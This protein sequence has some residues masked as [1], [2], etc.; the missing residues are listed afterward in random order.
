MTDTTFTHEL[1]SADDLREDS[2]PDLVA[3]EPGGAQK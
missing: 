1:A 3:A 2:K